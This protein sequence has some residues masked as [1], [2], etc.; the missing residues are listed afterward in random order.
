MANA[1][2]QTLPEPTRVFV[3][4]DDVDMPVDWVGWLEH[5]LANAGDSV[6]AVQGNVRVPLPG[7]TPALRLGA[8]RP[9]AGERPVGHR[10]P[11]RPPCRSRGRRRLRR[12]LPLGLSRGLRPGPVAARRRLAAGAGSSRHPPSGPPGVVVGQHQD[13]AGQRRRRPDRAAPQPR[14][15]AATRC[16]ARGT[17]AAHRVTV[18]VGMGA[19]AAAVSRRRRAATAAGLWWL[20][21]TM[22][23]AWAR[24]SPGSMPPSVPR[25]PAVSLG[26]SC[27]PADR[28]PRRSS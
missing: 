3:V 28:S 10:R 16:A 9:R 11:G 23:F 1:L 22:R 18:A 17:F 19:L 20:A 6:A 2:S 14:L 27:D 8:Q 7:G 24:S 13:A 26:S 12:A 21:R 25:L 4:D 15:A 5:D